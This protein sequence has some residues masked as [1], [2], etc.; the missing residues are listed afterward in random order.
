MS[1]VKADPQVAERFAAMG[2]EPVFNTA[3]EFQSFMRTDRA[4]WETVIT[5]A[6]VSRVENDYKGVS[7]AILAYQDRYGVLPGDDPAGHPR[8]QGLRHGRR[9]GRRGRSPCP[10][11]PTAP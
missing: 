10:A 5:N 8:T 1:K 4:K 11:T 2:I 6:K 9:S 7:A 3:K